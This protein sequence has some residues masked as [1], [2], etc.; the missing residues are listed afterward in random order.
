VV[1]GTITKVMP[2]GIF[3]ELD[4]DI[5]GLAHVLELSYEPIKHPDE[6]VKA[7]QQRQFKIISIEPGEHRLGLSIKQLEEAPKKKEKTE[8]KEEAKEEKTEVA[9]E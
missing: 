7:G 4:K 8:V 5:Q 2:F 9:A 3:V 6:V 1:E